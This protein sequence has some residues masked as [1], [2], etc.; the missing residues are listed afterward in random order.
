LSSF[1]RRLFSQ[2][3]S[4]FCMHVNVASDRNLYTQL[5]QKFNKILHCFT[6]A[7]RKSQN[8]KGVFTAHEINRTPVSFQLVRE[9]QRQQPHWSTHASRTS[10]ELT[11]LCPIHTAQQTRQDGPVCR[12]RRCE[13]SRPDRQIVLSGSECV[14]RSHCAVRHRPD[15]ERIDERAKPRPIL[16]L[17]WRRGIVVSGVRCMNEVNARRAR[18]QPVWVTVFGRVYHLGM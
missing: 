17:G 7:D 9:L 13:S 5:G 14:Q 3:F 4:L 6:C 16:L 18:L 12:I 10:R 1:L 15:T 8:C 11:D 2:A